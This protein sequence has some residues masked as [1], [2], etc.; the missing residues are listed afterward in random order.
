MLLNLLHGF[1]EDYRRFGNNVEN[2]EQG[3]FD[4]NNVTNHCFT[5][6]FSTDKRCDYPARRARNLRL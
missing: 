5:H 2:G 1:I 4:G 3:L 6:G